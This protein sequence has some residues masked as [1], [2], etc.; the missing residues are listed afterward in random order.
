L[1]DANGCIFNDTYQVNTPFPMDSNPS[2]ISETCAHPG[3]VQVEIFGGNAPYTYLWSNGET[4]ATILNL[5][6]ELYTL[7]VTDA[8]NCVATFGY[9]VPGFQELG[10]ENVTNIPVRCN[11][12]NSGFILINVN[13]G[14]SPYT[15]TW[16]N[17]AIGANNTNLQAGTYGLTVTDFVGCE[18]EESFEVG[19]TAPI[20]GS[21]EILSTVSAP[22]ASDA[23]IEANV[24]GGFPGYT[25]Q[26]NTGATTS[27]IANVAA[28]NYSV[29]VSDQFDCNEVLMV[30]VEDGIDCNNVSAIMN[31]DRSFCQES[32]A[33]F[34]AEPIG[35]NATYEWAFFNGPTS[36]SVFAGTA[37][38]LQV[39]FTFVE[40]GVKSVQ[41]TVTSANGCV[42]TSLEEL[43]ISEE[44]LDGG[45]IGNDESNCEGFETETIQNIELPGSVA[46]DYEYL[47]M[48]SFSNTA[49]TGVNDPNWILIENAFE[50]SYNPGIVDNSTYFVRF[51]KGSGCN[52]YL[53]SSNL[54]AKEVNDPGIT[55]DFEVD[56]AICIGT[57]ISFIAN[58]AGNSAAY[59]WNFF[60]GNNPRSSYLG[61]QSGQSIVFGFNNSG[62]VFVQL[63]IE[64]PG[65]CI[66]TKEAILIVEEAGSGACQPEN[67]NVTIQEFATTF[68]RFENTVIFWTIA[69]EIANVFYEVERSSDGGNTFEII[70]AVSGDLSSSYLFTDPAPLSG[71][72]HYRLKVIHPTGELLFSEIVAHQIETEVSGYTYPNPATTSTF[73]RLNQPLFA[74]TQLELSDNMGNIIE[75]KIVAAGTSEV[76]WDLSRLPDG[77]YYI[78]S[79]DRGR[80]TLLADVMKFNR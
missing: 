67:H 13:G 30:M 68:D 78:Y 77:Q 21:I 39:D 25:Y 80:R 29:T 62:E 74:D 35:N 63:L 47:W 37:N 42:A 57:D 49:P 20:T 22:G 7:T 44:L 28:G 50:A 8:S 69:D 4:T 79:N 9:N 27:M 40:F 75:I 38:G 24:S 70:G 10:L 58:D 1:T 65:G 3:A 60:A 36:N 26:W 64:L 41:L 17:G 23:S 34:S 66:L 18:I 43:T 6:A 15:Y 55:A 45:I 59:N 72:S 48:Y 14:S 33:T 73:L 11:G 51:S 12:D 2:I 46:G 71:V 19:Q 61:S 53:A 31:L 76:F 32:A 54:V 16:S 56:Q 52:E 5:A